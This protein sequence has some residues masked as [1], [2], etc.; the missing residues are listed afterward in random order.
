M[1]SHELRAAESQCI[2]FVKFILRFTTP[3]PVGRPP[4]FLTNLPKIRPNVSV[5]VA[6]PPPI[7]VIRH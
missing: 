2:E 1:S 5:P 6:F 4:N 7:I 3:S